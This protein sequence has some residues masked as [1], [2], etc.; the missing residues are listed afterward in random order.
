MLPLF[1]DEGP[2]RSKLSTKLAELAREGVW[3]GTSSWKYE[4]W[5]G[6][7]YTED[8]YKS[9]GRFSRKRFEAECLAEYAEV[10]KTVCV[11]AAVRPATGAST[12]YST[13]G[14]TR[15]SARA[16]AERDAARM[17]AAA[18]GDART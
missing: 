16:T 11:D 15:I 4:G 9:R 10:F 12:A 14:R 3:I 5:I 13:Q 7:I 8:R 18:R 2:T 6:Q 1:E 17:R